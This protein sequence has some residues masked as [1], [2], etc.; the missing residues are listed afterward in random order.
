MKDEKSIL[1]DIINMIKEEKLKVNETIMRGHIVE[2]SRSFT[3]FEHAELLKVESSLI[4]EGIFVLNHRQSLVLT[5]VGYE[6]IYDVK[7]APEKL[8][9]DK[10]A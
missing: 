5:R 4:K 3:S 8:P 10:E 7:L 1:N 2:Y 6:K 9:T